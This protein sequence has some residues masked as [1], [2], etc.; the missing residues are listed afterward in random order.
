VFLVSF[1]GQPKSAA[2]GWTIPVMESDNPQPISHSELI[3]YDYCVIVA[4]SRNFNDYEFFSQS[5]LGYLSAHNIEGKVA[6]ITGKASSG[7]D[8][9][10]IRWCKENDFPWC[11][12]PADWDKLDAPGAVVKTLR[13]GKQYNAVAGHDRNHEMAKVGT[14]LLV[15]WD[16][17]SVG[18]K[19][20]LS[21]AK[22]YNLPVSIVLVDVEK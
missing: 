9:L 6:F 7:A 1:I 2:I 19:N 11:E 4:G 16:G 5:L 17:V 15:F 10:I 20:M 3:D 8:E 22:K 21:W 18:T 14:N 12:F 13:G